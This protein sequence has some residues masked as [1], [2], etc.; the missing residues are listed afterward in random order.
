MKKALVIA[1]IF[2]FACSLFALDF[3]QDNYS[4][5]SSQ[6]NNRYVEVS[7]SEDFENG[8]G[9]WTTFDGTVP[10]GMWRTYD[11]NGEM[12]WWMGDESLAS[13]NHIGGYL[14]QTYVV[15]DTPA[16]T[17]DAN[18]LTFDLNYEIETP[19][20]EDPPYSGWDGCNVR[21]STDQGAT[22]TVI[23]PTSP[24]YNCSALFSFGS[25]HGEGTS[26]AG[27]GGSS[28]GWQQ[29]SVDMSSYLNQSVMIRF[30]F[31]SDGAYCTSDNASLFGM[32]VDNISCGT[33]SND[34]ST[35]T[36]FVPSSMVPLGGDIWNVRTSTTAPS[37]SNILACVSDNN[38]YL[39]NLLNYV[40]SPTITLPETGEIWADFKVKTNFRDP[41][42]SETNPSLSV[43]DYFGFEISPDNGSTWYAM[44]NPYHESN[45]QDY[46]YTGPTNGGLSD[47]GSMIDSY[48]SING[49]IDDYAGQD[50]KFR[51]YFRSDADTPGGDTDTDGY[52]IFV[53][54]F[55]IY[56]DIYLPQPT[57]MNGEFDQSTGVSLSWNAPDAASPIDITYTNGSWASYVN[58]SQPY[59][60]K[61]ENTYDIALPLHT[62]NIAMYDTSSEFTGTVDLYV[63]EDSNG[64]PSTTPLF[65]LEDQGNILHNEW[66]SV[67]VSELEYSVPAGATIWVAVGGFDT[68]TQG[69]LCDDSSPTSGS[70]CYTNG[71]WV[72]FN[73]SYETLVN[74][75]IS[76]TLLVPNPD[77][78]VADGYNVYHSLDQD[79]WSN[80]GSVTG[81]TTTSYIHTAPTAGQYN[82]YRVTA[83]Y[84]NNESET[85]NTASVFVITDDYVYLNNTDGTSEMGYTVGF[86]SSMAT[87]FEH[88]YV[89]EIVNIGVYVETLNTAPLVIRIYDDNN[90]VPADNYTYQT[91]YANASIVAGLNEIVAPEGMNEQ[92]S[93][94]VDDGKFWIAL[95][96]F[97][98]ASPIGVD[99]SASGNSMKKLGTGAW[100]AITEGNIIVRT[101]VRNGTQDTQEVVNPTIPMTINNY[102]NPFNPETTIKYNLPTSGQTTLKI[103]NM[104]GQLVD[105]LVN[106]N[107]AQGPQEIVWTADNH[108]SGV[109]FYKLENGGKTVVNK[110]VLMK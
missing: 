2:I 70:A 39:P 78:P 18:T 77:V 96:E 53:D 110:M 74:C 58:D 75:G 42:S 11:Y 28:N 82:Y 41:Q 23:N 35:N 99:T 44:N 13:G 38:Q 8:M 106:E 21:I 3:Q 49:R 31:A 56:N 59:A 52:G 36:G 90:G 37:G 79:S 88:D 71:M 47:W 81:A 45:I 95:F 30:A 50:V 5:Q 76:A 101:L 20:G 19:G 27:W 54:D 66:T 84:G 80:I 61:I 1:S 62:I 108:T 107:Q 12:V 6:L 22:W 51:I 10:A 17:V 64:E 15:L 60:M 100:E 46:V 26:I 55:T 104:K 34:A 83:Y 48:S 43:L 14:D 105:T 7:Y 93:D 109:Y 24:A 32:M 97:P 102:P 29:A 86:N 73:E 4:T 33:F 16:F 40:I 63:Y 85:S 68:T 87:Y 89:P 72:D 67:N 65:T 94:I 103:Y 25:I 92:I 91:T 69:L 98:N 9:D 57:G